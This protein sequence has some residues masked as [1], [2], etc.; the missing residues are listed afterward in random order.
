MQRT[1]KISLF[2]VES[3]AIFKSKNHFFNNNKKISI[4]PHSVMSLLC[5]HEKQE[6]RKK[7]LWLWFLSFSWQEEFLGVTYFHAWLASSL[8]NNNNKSLSSSHLFVILSVLLR[9][10]SVHCMTI[11]LLMHILLLLQLYSCF[12]CVA[13]HRLREKH[14]FTS[15]IHAIKYFMWSLRTH[16]LLFSLYTI[17]PN[18]NNKF[19]R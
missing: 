17:L 3:V 11:N 8:F 12:Y 6:M 4:L 13:P 19:R 1:I 10:L 16:S 7:I 9:P 5:H 18:I 14:R 15:L 2:L